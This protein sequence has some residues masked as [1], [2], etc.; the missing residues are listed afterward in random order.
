MTRSRD[1]KK[2]NFRFTL[3]V[4]DGISTIVIS[5]LLAF[6]IVSFKIWAAL[7][8]SIIV[9]FWILY[10][11]DKIIKK[12]RREN[13]L[14]QKEKE[15][16][17]KLTEVPLNVQSV[18]DLAQF[19][20]EKYFEINY[21]QIK[22]IYRISVGILITGFF[23]I[24]S[25]IAVSFIKP[26]VMVIAYLTSITGL[27]TE[28]IGATVMFIYRS[29]MRQGADHVK[30]LEKIN[31]VGMSIHIVDSMD[32]AIGKNDVTLKNNTKS[33]IAKMTLNMNILKDKSVSV[34]NETDT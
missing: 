22:S 34:K 20:L 30:T 19:N 26:Q 15:I 14:R 17:E 24:V 13:D 29:T 2:G 25:G 27:L 6:E 33:E 11:Y 16:G 10:Y 28:F 23:I 12:Q 3:L 18:W 4:I 9:K 7:T 21:S 32:E 31:S 1:T 8:L 5:M